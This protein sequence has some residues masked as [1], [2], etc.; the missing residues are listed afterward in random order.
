M[1]I[2]DGHNLIPKIPGWSLTAMDDEKRLIELLQSYVNARRKQVEV[3]FDGAPVGQAGVR[4]YGTIRAH[5]VPLGKT[6]DD[7]IIQFLV[8]LGKNARN[9][10]VVSSDRRVRS[11]A[12]ALRAEVITSEVFAD[13][14]REVYEALERKAEY[15]RATARKQHAASPHK[16][17]DPTPGPAGDKPA[18]RS[19]PGG[20]DEWLNLFGIDP[21]DA[22]KPIEP[23]ESRYRPKKL[24]PEPPRPKKG[25]PSR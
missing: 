11:E 5:F 18:A 25:K 2:I 12:S 21:A 20:V 14:L 13:D 7:A 23:P 1:Y 16:P 19:A 6:A 10:T 9:V 15:K 22:D 4:Q 8:G 3:F 24:N 17:G